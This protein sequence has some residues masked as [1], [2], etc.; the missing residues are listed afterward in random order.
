[1]LSIDND[2]DLRVKH[3]VDLICKD[4][5]YAI[6]GAAM[7][8]HREL[9]CG[10]LE[11]VYQEAL[12]MELTTRGIPYVREP[13]LSLTYHGQLLKKYYTP[14][15]ICYSQVIVELKSVEYLNR[16]HEYQLLNYLKT[17]KLP[18]GLLINFGEPSLK[19]RKL[20]N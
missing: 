8:V 4:E 10:F 14:D 9:G 7:A 1:M 2:N 12:A 13:R 3:H 17:A 20:V 6:I 16:V 18:T 15:F 11:A 19:F 5:V